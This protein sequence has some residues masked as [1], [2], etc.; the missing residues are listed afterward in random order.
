MRREMEEILLSQEKMLQKNQLSERE[1][2]ITIYEFHLKKT[3]RFF[4]ENKIP[5]VD[6]NYNDLMKDSDFELTKLFDFLSIEKPK[7]LTSVLKPN[8]YRNRK[9]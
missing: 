5:F 2:F 8:L 3:Y 6:I 7:N 1:K 9:C 4:T